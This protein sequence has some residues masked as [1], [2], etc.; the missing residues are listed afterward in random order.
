MPWQTPKTNW[1]A[2]DYYNAGDLNRVENN[3]DFV[4]TYLVGLGYA[5]PS[6]TT[7]VSRINESYDDLTSINRIEA[8]L[9]LIKDNFVTPS[10]WQA[11]QTWTVTTPLTHNDANRWESNISALYELAQ[12]VPQ[13]FRYAGTFNLSQEVLPQT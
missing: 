3:I 5:I 12:K 4:R 2:S 7:D 13:S 10:S 11:G 8:N 1:T 9:T 6:I